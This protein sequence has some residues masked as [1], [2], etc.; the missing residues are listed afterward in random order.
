[1][2]TFPLLYF[3]FWWLIW[4]CHSWFFALDRFILNSCLLTSNQFMNHDMMGL[5]PTAECFHAWPLLTEIKSLYIGSSWL[6]SNGPPVSPNRWI[7]FS[8]DWCFDARSHQG[9]T[10][11][12]WRRKNIGFCRLCFS[13]GSSCRSCL[14]V[15]IDPLPEWMFISKLNSCFVNKFDVA[16]W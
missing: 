12:R 16:W 4:W 6:L 15:F 8:I 1:M 7:R 11:I 13:L 2:S 10:C 9:W 3:R 5:I 14:I